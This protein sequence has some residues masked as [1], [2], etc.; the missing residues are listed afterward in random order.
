[1]SNWIYYCSGLDVNVIVQKLG[2]KESY[3]EIATNAGTFAVAYAVHKV[4]APVRIAI[5]LGATPFIVRY[6]RSA[7]IIKK[8]K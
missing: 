6:L 7:G 4:F 2:I 3:G 1:M 8:R 5:T